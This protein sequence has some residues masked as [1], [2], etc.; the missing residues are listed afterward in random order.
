MSPLYFSLF[1]LFYLFQ[2]SL[3]VDR[4]QT[5]TG[6]NFNGPKFLGYNNPVN[7][8]FTLEDINIP[9]SSQALVLLMVYMTHN[10]TGDLVIRL[11]PPSGNTVMVSNHRG[12]NY[13]NGF[14]DTIF[15]DMG[16]ESVATFTFGPGK[17]ASMVRPEEPFDFQNQNVN[18]KWIISFEDTVEGQDGSVKQVIFGIQGSKKETIQKS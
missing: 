18:G 1:F 12:G 16:L 2:L 10:S 11:T 9:L 4:H 8:D 14:S 15:S 7:V 3:S 13:A 5:T 17:S 6:G